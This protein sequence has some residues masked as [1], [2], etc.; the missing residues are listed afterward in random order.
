[1]F[2]FVSRQEILPCTANGENVDGLIANPKDDPVH[3]PAA[4]LEQPLAKVQAEV[5]RFGSGGVGGGSV[6]SPAALG[7][8]G[9]G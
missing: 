6:P 5:I 1:M 9:L 3:M 7:G 4:S 8:R 2:E